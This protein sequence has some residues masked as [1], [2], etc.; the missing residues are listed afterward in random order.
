MEWSLQVD[1]EYIQYVRA[2]FHSLDISFDF[3]CDFRQNPVTTF[4]PLNGA[5][6]VRR[7]KP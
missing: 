2:L 3:D 6:R 1:L 7:T 5:F 4:I